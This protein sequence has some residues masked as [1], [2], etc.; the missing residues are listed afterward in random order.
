MH[1]KKGRYIEEERRMDEKERKEGS[2][3]VRLMKERKMKEGSQM[4]KKY[5][6]KKGMSIIVMG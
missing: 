3:K 2:R 4:W 5:E 1:L 6:R